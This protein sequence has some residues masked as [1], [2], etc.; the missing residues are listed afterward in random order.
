MV[1]QLGA[2][3]ESFCAPRTKVLVFTVMHGNVHG[4]C[5]LLLGAVVAVCTFTEHHG[6]QKSKIGLNCVRALL[7]PKSF[8]VLER[9]DGN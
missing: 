5:T 4:E 7:Y 1:L 6:N 9:E 8:R 3:S 2:D